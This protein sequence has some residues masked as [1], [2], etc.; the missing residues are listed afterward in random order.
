MFLFKNFLHTLLPFLP[1]TSSVCL[2]HFSFL[3]L[4]F[5]LHLTCLLLCPF[6]PTRDWSFRTCAGWRTCWSWRRQT[7]CKPPSSLLR[8]CS[9]H[10][11]RVCL[12]RE[13]WHSSD[14][15]QPAQYVILIFRGNCIDIPSKTL[16]E[17]SLR[18]GQRKASGSLDVGCWGLL[19]ALRCGHAHPTTQRIQRLGHPALTSH[20]QDPTLTPHTNPHIPHRQLPHTWRGGP[21]YGEYIF[22]FIINSWD[23]SD[24]WFCEGYFLLN[25]IIEY[26]NDASIVCRHILWLQ[27]KS[28]SKI[29]NLTKVIRQIKWSAEIQLNLDALYDPF[30]K[31]LK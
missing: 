9:E 12:F 26:M 18:L 10:M 4:Y 8:P 17:T 7:C 13:S 3:L 1:I 30:C 24:L 19:P 11:V 2:F 5:S 22:F 28:S 20:P 14:L 16:Y 27:K 21:V 31:R 23:A 29:L 25:E 6:S 15:H